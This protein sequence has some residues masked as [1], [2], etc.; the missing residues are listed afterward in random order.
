[1]SERTGERGVFGEVFQCVAC[2]SGEET[3]LDRYLRSR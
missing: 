1:M 2:F 3:R